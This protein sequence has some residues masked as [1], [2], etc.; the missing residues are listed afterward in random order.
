MYLYDN[1]LISYL[2]NGIKCYVKKTPI[3][4]NYFYFV[5][6]VKGGSLCDK[7]YCGESHFVEHSLLEFDGENLYKNKLEYNIKAT[8]SLDKTVFILSCKNKKENN[9]KLIVIMKN[10][11]LG[12][13]L[14]ENN[15]EKIRKDIIIEYNREMSN[16]ISY[17]KMYEQ[18]LKLSKIADSMPIGNINDINKI[19]H[20]DIV[21]YFNENYT[22][23]NM[24]VL[25]LGKF[26]P[27]TM[28]KKIE[29]LFSNNF[30]IE[31]MEPIEKDNKT[32][33]DKSSMFYKK[34]IANINS[35][36]IFIL[37]PIDDRHIVKN[38]L[39]ESIIITFLEEILNTILRN[40]VYSVKIEINQFSYRNRFI[41]IIVFPKKPTYNLQREVNWGCL[42]V[43]HCLKTKQYNK[44]LDEVF[45]AYYDSFHQQDV[46]MS[47]Q[48]NQLI[49]TFL[50]NKQMY[51]N[52]ELLICLK[53]L[54][55]EEIMLTLKNAIEKILQ[56]INVHIFEI[57][58]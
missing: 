18:L 55:K 45:A 11:I 27:K 12:K 31:N 20:E 39:I 33:L 4:F 19:K 8:T 28:T 43:L 44:L 3:D 2:N 6:V 57:V 53:T 16:N 37:N 30:V 26:N 56:N 13:Y 49:D 24:A 17:C 50:Y 10:I 15:L 22:P 1:L 48:I 46:N 58:K 32:D 38:E 25:C 54:S 23:E 34:F 41:H 29:E 40:I 7:K 21:N 42:R 5:L 14:N 52:N 47:Q 35:I 51:D 36:H 9:E